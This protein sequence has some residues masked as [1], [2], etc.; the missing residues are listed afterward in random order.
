MNELGTKE[1]ENEIRYL[2][3]KK[4]VRKKNT[5]RPCCLKDNCTNRTSNEFCN[6]HTEKKILL[7]T[8][9]KKNSQSLNWKEKIK[10]IFEK[11]KEV[12]LVKIIAKENKQEYN[13]S[14]L[15][16]LYR[17]DKCK[18]ICKCKKEHIISVRDICEKDNGPLCYD[19][20]K[21]FNV[22][23]QG[24]IPWNE[25]QI[26][27][28]FCKILF[29]WNIYKNKN[30]TSFENYIWSIPSYKFIQ[31]NFS[32]FCGALRYYK[33]RFNDLIE[34]CTGKRLRW[35][36]GSKQ[37]SDEKL[38]NILTNIYENDGIEN[39]TP[40]KLNKNHKNFHANFVERL[41]REI[42][43]KKNY[44]EP[45]KRN[46]LPSLYCCKLINKIDERKEWIIKNCPHHC[47]F[48]ELIEYHFKPIVEKKKDLP[49]FVWFMKNNHGWANNIYK[50]DKIWDDVKKALNISINS[51]LSK[52][53]KYWDSEGE[54]C[55]A[56]FL[57]ER[58]I[59]VKK[60][61][62]YPVAF[63][64]V[65]KKRQGSTYDLE[66]YS[67]IKKK[68]II[69]EIW[70]KKFDDKN[71]SLM[72]GYLE[73]R[74]RKENFWKNR[75][76][77][78]LGIEVLDT[79][80]SKKLI[81]ILKP[82]IG[83]IKPIN[84]INEGIEIN[85]SINKKAEILKIC[86]KIIEKHGYLPN[87]YNNREEY[88]GLSNKINK[89]MGGIKN[90]REILKVVNCG[91]K[92]VLWDF[93]KHIIPA[94]KWYKKQKKLDYIHIPKSYIIPNDHKNV[95]LQGMKLGRIYETLSRGC[96]I[97]NNEDS[98]KKIKTLNDINFIFCPNEYNFNLTVKGLQFFKNKNGHL[99]VP[100]EFIL[101]HMNNLK[102]GNI[103]NNI[104]SKKSELIYY[105]LAETKKNFFNKCNIPY[106][107]I[108]DKEKILNNL[109]FIWKKPKFS[110]YEFEK[111]KKKKYDDAYSLINFYNTHDRLPIRTRK[112]KEYNIYRYLK[113]AYFFN[114]KKS[115]IK[116]YKVVF[117]EITNLLEKKISPNWEI[118]KISKKKKKKV[119]LSI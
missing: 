34:D 116:E 15:P 44:S 71:K 61:K 30:V 10:N 8:E 80:N 78:F 37:W 58:G 32:E 83:L 87:P 108:E 63:K 72:K 39:L 90:V 36:K 62:L 4:Q 26:K 109:G 85:I 43:D 107:S 79:Y 25:I 9:R 46:G 94:L 82:Y 110:L 100:S 93:Y 28:Y 57:L 48:N 20:K 5:W 105:T 47:N 27:K 68:W 95:T 115:R 66:F 21:I 49:P 2:N 53:G 50:F 106:T 92:K 45:N 17:V 3:G 75:E 55:F 103:V 69:V 88:P 60:G 29:I 14:E 65:N 23:K 24:R 52:D 42:D 18:I 16:L 73:K 1:N 33:V 111:W 98:I 117:E 77:I 113:K 104:R 76:E 91:E 38:I 11:N 13:I 96:Y 22:L 64:K 51:H 12:T 99:D 6:K 70:G 97:G 31:N 114:Q 19:C 119:S 81:K 56:N 112:E 41:G 54:V 118:L 102:L 84:K 67:P 40:Q 101:S 86:E 35:G 89:Y 59:Q 74:K 7:P